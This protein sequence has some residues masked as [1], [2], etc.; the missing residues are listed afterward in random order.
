MAGISL[1]LSPLVICS[2]ALGEEVTMGERRKGRQPL[3]RLEDGKRQ[4]LSVVPFPH[5]SFSLSLSHFV[6]CPRLKNQMEGDSK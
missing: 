4:L 5:K 6:S 2:L 3:D 1:F